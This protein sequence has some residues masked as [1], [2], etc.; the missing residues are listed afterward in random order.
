MKTATGLEYI[1]ITRGFKT[2]EFISQKQ[3]TLQKFFQ[4]F[5]K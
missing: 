2:V 1:R 4:F 5:Y 3:Q